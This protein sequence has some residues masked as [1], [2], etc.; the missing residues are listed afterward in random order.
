MKL[1]GPADAGSDT[2]YVS[3]RHVGD[4]AER[5]RD[6]ASIEARCADGEWSAYLVNQIMAPIRDARQNIPDVA[7]SWDKLEELKLFDPKDFSSDIDKEIDSMEK[8]LVRDQ[9]LKARSAFE[10][11]SGSK[12]IGGGV[13]VGSPFFEA[14]ASGHY[15]RIGGRSQR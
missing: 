1:T 9:L 7:G 2:I 8:G 13:A 10:S 6:T 12:E 5:I 4:A 15:Q 3:R 14:A 11:E